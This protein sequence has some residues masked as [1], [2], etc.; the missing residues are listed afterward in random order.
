MR[1]CRI[2]MGK[3]LYGNCGLMYAKAEISSNG[4]LNPK[5]LINPYVFYMKDGQY[6]IVSIR[7]DSSE[8][9]ASDV[10]NLT[11]DTSEGS[12]FDI[13]SEETRIEGACERNYFYVPESVGKKLVSKFSTIYNTGVTVP[14]VKLYTDNGADACKEQLRNTK[15]Q[16]QYS[17]GSTAEKAVD[18]DMS[19][20][21]FEK[22]GE[23]YVTGYIQRA[24]SMKAS[25]DTS[26][27]VNRADPCIYYNEDDG[28]YYFIATDDS[29]GN[30]TFGI[31]KSETIEGLKDA[32]ESVILSVDDYDDVNMV[33][34][35]PEIHKIGRH[36]YIFFAAN[37]AGGWDVQCF[38]MKLGGD[39]MTKKEDWDRPIRFLGMDDRP[40]KE[41]TDVG[42]ITLDMTSFELHGETYVCWTQ[43]DFGRET[44][45]IIF[46]ATIDP[47]MP[48]KLTSEPTL[49]CRPDYGWDNN[50]DT[51]VD[52]GPYAIIAEDNIYITF[53]GSAVGATYCVGLLKADIDADL[54]SSE[55]WTKS[56]YPILYPRAVEGEAGP[57]HNS[58]TRDAAGNLVFVYHARPVDAN[59]NVGSRNTGLRTVHFDV[60][61]EPVLYMYGDLELACEYEEV[62]LKVTVTSMATENSNQIKDTPPA[63]TVQNPVGQNN[64]DTGVA[65]V[66]KGLVITVGKFTYKVTAVSKSGGG[67]VSIIKMV[68]KKVKSAVIGSTVSIGGAKYKITAISNGAFK[69]CKKL[70]NV[71][72]GKNVTKIGNKAFANCTGL[73]K[74]VV[75]GTKIQKVGKNA[76]GKTAKNTSVKVPKKALKKYKKLFRG[77]KVK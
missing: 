54:L 17:D 16:L 51:P 39:D 75:K 74:I 41:A 18:W 61:G 36:T 56:N 9:A 77:I 8:T 15:V 47:S 13:Q 3:A 60:D 12:A 5:N 35:A 69:G 50:D 38:V 52:E 6:G 21:D 58:Y 59:G 67:S 46:I 62:S 72:I 24:P 31:R 64:V 71:I 76:F 44:G 43:R 68:G 25:A 28:Y 65:G 29:N 57:G 1:D 22:E 26:L 34:W 33:L 10:L 23:Y 63:V 66:T 11:A 37:P 70:K 48:W 45:S 19:G 27:G 49:L 30:A 2:H 40:L 4:K 7:T 55:S 20:I 42:G 53:S 32:E 73:K 14:E